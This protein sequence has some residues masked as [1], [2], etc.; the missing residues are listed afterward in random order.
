MWALPR[1]RAE[2]GAR[3][4]ERH[5][6]HPPPLGEHAETRLPPPRRAPLL[7]HPRLCERRAGGRELGGVFIHACRGK[8]G[9]EVGKRVFHTSSSRAF[10][11]A[12]RTASI[13]A[14]PTEKAGPLSRSRYRRWI[15]LAAFSIVRRRRSAT[16]LLT[17]GPYM[18]TRR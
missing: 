9:A 5:A 17:C 3:L 18:Q 6:E 8:E 14:P 15:V 11:R 2:E 12:S 1:L 7:D 13:A 10:L 4:A 16:R